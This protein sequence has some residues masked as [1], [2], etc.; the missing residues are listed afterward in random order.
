MNTLARF[1]FLSTLLLSAAQAE[2]PFFE[3]FA[4]SL[5]VV[6]VTSA[7]D[8]GIGD[9][10][11]YWYLLEANVRKVIAGGVSEKTIKFA[12]FATPGGNR[13]FPKQLA[14]LIDIEGSR[15]HESLGVRYEALGIQRI[16]PIVC[17]G[18]TP[19]EMF[20]DDM[21]FRA[22]V[23]IDSYFGR[24][25]ACYRA[26]SLVGPENIADASASGTWCP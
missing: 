4:P 21:R 6:D 3:E 16:D 19:Q 2:Q 18:I 15:R 23:T 14:T 24:G 25:D 10:H 1:L 9:G 8:T 20:P 13:V 26:E 22:T 5:L 11:T 12:I 17:F 7:E